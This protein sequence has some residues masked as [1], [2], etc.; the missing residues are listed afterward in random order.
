MKN[1]DFLKAA[2]IANKGIYDNKNIYE[3]TLESLSLAMERG[4]A[5]YFHVHCTKD[6]ILVLYHDHDLTRIMNLKDRIGET[7]YEELNYICPFHIPTFEEA[8][9][10]ISGNVPI[11]ID[12]RCRNN[13]FYLEKELARALDNYQGLFALVSADKK[14]IKWFNKNRPNYIIGE[15]LV[16]R[17]SFSKLSFDSLFAYY[18]IITEFKSVALNDYHPHKIRNLKTNNLILGYVVDTQEKYL[19]YKD[20]CDN[21]YLDNISGLEL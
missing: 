5:I 2:Y 20:V 7:T 1:T 14:I 9:V 4:F 19:A 17:K 21:I 6:N 12:P 10:H 11:I 3:N 18:S 13:D 8:L 16:K 15:T